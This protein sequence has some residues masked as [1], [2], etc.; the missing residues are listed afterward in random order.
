MGFIRLKPMLAAFH[1][2]IFRRHEEPRHNSFSYQHVNLVTVEN[3][4]ITVLDPSTQ[5][6]IFNLAK[7][8]R[9]PPSISAS[10]LA[11]VLVCG[12]IW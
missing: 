11:S 10:F 8:Y 12:K 7:H 5:K 2:R 3:H 9:S 4:R 1:Q 6:E